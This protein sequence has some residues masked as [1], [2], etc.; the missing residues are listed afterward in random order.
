MK[1]VVR[2]DPTHWQALVQKMKPY[3]NGI[4][5][6]ITRLCAI[7][8]VKDQ[9]APDAP[10]GEQTRRALECFLEIG[11]NLG[12]RAVNLDNRAGYVEFGSGKRLVAALCHLDIVPAGDGW[13]D[14]PYRPVVRNGH[15]IGRG[16]LDNKGPAVAVLYAMKA[17]LD[18]GFQP[19][20][21]IRLIV[22]LD[23]ESGS[24]CMAHYVQVA[25]L[26]DAG[27]TPD[28]G[29][30]VIYAEKGMCWANLSI[31]GGQS[32]RDGLRLIGA[33]AGLRANVVPSRCNLT[34]L[35]R[36]GTVSSDVIEG[37]LAHASTPWEGRNAIG[38]AME[39]AAVRLAAAGCRHPFVDFYRQTIGLEWDGARLDVAGS[40]ES[41]PLTLNAGILRLNEQAAELTLD[42][43]YPVTWSYADF[44]ERLRK[45]AAA[46]GA[47]VSFSKH[48]PPL[49]LAKD[50]SLVS[51]LSEVYTAMT[52]INAPPIAIGGGTYARTMPNIVAFG[53]TFPGDAETAHQ[54]GE[55]I[56]VD[57]LL[58]A[59]A[60]FR[61]ALQA[62]S[63]TR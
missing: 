38:A 19:D 41:G 48:S 15:L 34:W 23:E 12:F 44:T 4:V 26:P 9:A 11:R 6:D 1:P 16:T 21:R 7:P 28:A 47:Q 50:S 20:G 62:L 49:H 42:I 63:R 45:K 2:P 40:D 10:F 17:L 5:H 55:F 31:T 27:F 3:E 61:Q 30:P 43:R 36:D 29:F 18:E 8:S 58:A 22:G 56:A 13:T 24:A 39:A 37:V 54:A 57:S 46:L 53:P 32:D 52:G 33:D 35:E 14:D 51:T 60:L 59:A 25:D